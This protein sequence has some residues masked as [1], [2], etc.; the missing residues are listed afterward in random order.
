MNNLKVTSKIIV[1][2]TVFF[3][4]SLTF[5]TA[6]VISINSGGGLGFVITPSW[7]IEDFFLGANRFPIVSNVILNSSLGLNTTNEN[8]TV[9]Y[10]STDADN[11][12][13]TNI[14]DWRRDGDS[15]AVLNMPFDKRVFSTS[16]GAIRDY[17]TYG[18]NGTLGGGNISRVPTWNSS[19]K[20]GGAYSFG[21]SSNR[22]YIQTISITDIDYNL[23]LSAWV[24]PKKYPSER[25]TIILGSGAYYL[26]LA[27]DGSLQAYWYGRNP[28]GYHSSGAGTVQL[29]SWSHVLVVW[30]NSM[31]N[32]YVNGI[33]KKT[34]AVSSQPGNTASSVIVG[35]ENTGRQFN[36]SIDEVQVFNRS[37]TPEQIFVIYQAGLAGHQVETMVSQETD[38]GDVWQ[39]AITPNDV[40]D[41]GITVLSN[42]LTIEN[43]IPNDPENVLLV[44][45][46]GRNES[47]TDLNCSAKVSDPDHSSFTVYVDWLESDASQ[48]TQ[49]FDSQGNDTLFWALLGNGNL[50]LGDIW[51]CSVRIYDGYDYSGW[52]DSNEIEII[53]ITEPNITIVSPL[54]PADINYS[55]L[56]V[57]FNISI[58]ENEAI[59]KCYYDL[60]GTS[61]ISMNEFNSTYYW[62]EPNNLIPGNHNVTFWCNDTSGNWGMN[63]TNF[64][65]LDEAAIAIQLSPSL[66]WSVNWSLT[67]IP[68]DD[69]N[70]TGNNGPNAT[71]YYINISVITVT[72]DLY[73]KADGNLTN[74]ALDI[75][76]LGNET[77]GFNTTNS[78]VPNPSKVTMDTSYVKIGDSLTDGSVVYIKFYLDA[79]ASQPAGKYTNNLYFKAVSHGATP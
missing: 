53:D 31:V 57:D 55:S 46:N 29:N 73:V 70:A 23:T 14:T 8:L 18:N 76:I 16:A 71:D 19:G 52:I 1:I 77:Y 64:T 15:V 60:N 50:T 51:K 44:S 72:A 74:D 6:D 13:I 37:L 5:V 33:L 9:Y 20:I 11:D 25:S 79:P 49:Q 59:S 66:D 21:A 48:F 43:A 24:H 26:S 67:T 62:Y 30:N 22:E 54:P 41:D 12:P 38:R 27:N 65:V 75:I 45:L 28:A 4:L 39:V 32:L 36:G 17:S 47:D 68:V 35:A 42:T 2:V 56:E 34:V 7:G 78:S 58:S 69:E 10:T 63:F 61:N 40:Y 3:F